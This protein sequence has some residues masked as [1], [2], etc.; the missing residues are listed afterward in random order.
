MVRTELTDQQRYVSLLIDTPGEQGQ[1]RTL[2]IVGAIKASECYLHWHIAA[3]FNVRPGVV[4]IL[5]GWAYARDL[6]WATVGPRSI[7]P[8]D[9]QAACACR[10]QV[11][12]S[13][14]EGRRPSWIARTLLLELPYVFEVLRRSFPTD[15]PNWTREFEQEA[16]AEWADRAWRRACADTEQADQESLARIASLAYQY[17]TREQRLLLSE[18]FR[19]ERAEVVDAAHQL[20]LVPP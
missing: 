2:K 1:E 13:F 19:D 18:L 15:E 9:E 6:G 20:P 8:Q 14:E 5:A 12:R 17:L 16:R 7:T 10:A 4:R 3:S 11:R